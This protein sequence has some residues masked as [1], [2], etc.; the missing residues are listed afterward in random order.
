M[1]LV[2]RNRLRSSIID[3]G[4]LP[5][6]RVVWVKLQNEKI[7]TLGILGVYG[8]NETP[9][10]ARLW[11]ELLNTLDFSISWIVLGDFNMIE[12]SEEQRGGNYSTIL[13]DEKHAWFHLLRR[14][15]VDDTILYRPDHLRF[16]WDSKKRFRHVLAMQYAPLQDR[17]PRKIDRGY[18]PI[19][20]GTSK[21]LSAQLTILP[22]FPLS[23]HAPMLLSISLQG[24]N[25]RPTQYKMNIDHLADPILQDKIC[26]MWNTEKARYPSTTSHGA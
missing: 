12:C 8:P 5:S 26:S 11:K 25:T 2:I 18:C 21:I 23:D 13:G 9:N 7:G 15:K 17:V 6:Q 3:E 10:R 24:D 19:V 4:I 22:G 14:M 1:E 16:T 20:K